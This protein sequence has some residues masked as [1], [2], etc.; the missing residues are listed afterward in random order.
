[1]CTKRIL[2][3]LRL[4]QSKRSTPKQTVQQALRSATECLVGLGA[5][6]SDHRSKLLSSFIEE[7]RLVIRSADD[8]VNHQTTLQLEKLVDSV[9]H[10]KRVVDTEALLGGISSRDMNPNSRKSLVNIINKTARYRE[11]ARYLYRTSK[12][13]TLLRKM[14]ITTIDLPVEAYVRTT[15]VYATPTLESV[16]TR[17]QQS[18]CKADVTRIHHLI[19]ATNLDV[20]LQ[21]ARQ[22]TNTLHKSK[23]HA[24]IQLLYYLERN[25]SSLPPNVIASSKDACFLCNAFIHMHGKVHTARTHGRLY[26]GWRL[27]FM[28][29]FVSLEQRF[30]AELAFQI[31]ASLRTLLSRGQKS[32]YPDPNESTLLML[33]H[34]AS[35]L[36]SPR[37]AQDITIT[38]KAVS[39]LLPSEARKE[40]NTDTNIS[41]SEERSKEE[42]MEIS[43]GQ[44]RQS[45]EQSGEE[46]NDQ[47]ETETTTLRP[48]EKGIGAVDVE[49][50]RSRNSTTSSE[51]TFVTSNEVDMIQGRS[52]FLE[53]SGLFKTGKL[54][55]YVEYPEQTMALQRTF[56]N[57]THNLAWLDDRE[58]ERLRAIKGS[59]LTDVDQ[60]DDEITCE[61][62][63]QG[64]L[65]VAARG[66][67]IQITVRT[68]TS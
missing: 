17:A 6:N 66:V 38:R 1:M 28:P 68:E 21:F 33:P 60:V 31:D 34:S 13:N 50:I 27:P 24:E 10:L 42:F 8:W 51:A 25:P 7:A 14:R 43:Q 40:P 30:N 57:V 65:F 53:G 4:S 52:I 36:H 32:V 39:P 5:K 11:I 41:T 55:L 49:A 20:K 44:P 48:K 54:N 47:S 61:V 37:V 2:L 58:A 35:T 19:D 23:I 45:E 9:Y 18:F 12:K 29:T 16:L 26:P 64:C 63:D 67:V 46:F 56:G 15:N 22:V 59:D 3:R 62:D